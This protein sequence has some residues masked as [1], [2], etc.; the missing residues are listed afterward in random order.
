MTKVYSDSKMAVDNLSIY[1]YENQITSFLGHNGAGKTT[2][3]SCLTGLLPDTSGH[4]Y[5]Y[6]KDIHTD[7]TEIRKSIG[8]CPQ[9]IILFEKLNV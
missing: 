6:G 5:V 8:V 9:H 7:I 1:F 4:A 2:T 3:I